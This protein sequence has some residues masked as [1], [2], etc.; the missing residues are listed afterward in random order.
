[1]AIYLSLKYINKHIKTFEINKY[2]T[3]RS[4]ILLLKNI[5]VN[6][7]HVCADIKCHS[8]CVEVRSQIHRIRSLLPLLNGS[9]DGGQVSPVQQDPL[10]YS[11]DSL[12]TDV[13]IAI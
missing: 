13:I 4:I 2:I 9:K 8:K 6:I 1:M 10:S 11:G 5:L 7:L 3:F 12:T